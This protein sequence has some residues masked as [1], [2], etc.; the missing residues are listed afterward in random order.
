M[1]KQSG[2]GDAFYVAGHDLSGDTN[3][4]GRVGGGPLALDL[5]GINKYAYER[6]GGKRDGAFEFVSYFNAASGA[7]H[8]VL[9]ALPTTNVHAMYL[10]GE[11]LGRPGAGAILKQVGYD[12]T[13]DAEGNLTFAVQGLATDY[14]I[15]WGRQLT[16][17]IRV[18]TGATNGTSID[19]TSSA[20]LGAQAFL[21]I[22]SFGTGDVTVTIQ[23]SANNADWTDVADLSFIEITDFTDGPYGERI[24]TARDAT[25]RRYLRVVTTTDSG[26]DS[27][28][29]AVVIRKNRTAVS[30]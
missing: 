30:F 15:E 5:T 22:F 27:L 26:F 7:S 8:E 18:D 11:G 20:S 16:P 24:Q 9:G 28:E 21:Q 25:I 10:R 19:T 2:M 12:P 3:S 29:F 23:D 1:T 4:L 13:R 6:K 17:G 14:G